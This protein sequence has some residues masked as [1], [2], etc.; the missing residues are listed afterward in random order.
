MV[1]LS[2]VST[3][4]ASFKVKCGDAPIPPTHAEA[5]YWAGD[6]DTYYEP[7]VKFPIVPITQTIEFIDVLDRGMI[8][9]YF[10]MADGTR[11]GY[12]SAGPIVAENN[13]TYIYSF[14]NGTIEAAPAV[15]LSPVW[16]LVGL[17][18]AT[19]LFIGRKRIRIK[20][21]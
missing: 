14:A 15:G 11:I 10:Y 13:K 6:W 20:K 7:V 12:Y 8:I 2:Q 16:I 1:N 9:A 18:L 17:S 3:T 4:R 19:V 5:V 21:R